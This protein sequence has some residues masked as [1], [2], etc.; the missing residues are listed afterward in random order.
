MIKFVKIL[1]FNN[2][3]KEEL[4]DK[5]VKERNINLYLNDKLI[6]RIV[7]S[8]PYEEELVFGYLFLKGYINKKNDLKRIVFK[9]EDKGHC[10]DCHTEVEN[11]SDNFLLLEKQFS[12][13]SSKLFVLMKE[14]LSKSIVFRQTGGTH[15][16]GLSDG[17]NLIS[18]FED[19]SRQSTI[20]KLAG[21]AILTD[22][23]P[24]A[25]VLFTSG[26]ISETAVQYAKRLGVMAVVS[27]SAPTDFAIEVA[28]DADIMLIGF[29]R[30]SRFNIYSTNKNLK[31]I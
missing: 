9:D 23:W 4:E 27:R 26:R 30:G 28:K 5:I 2:G 11:I 25:N 13:N 15:I 8:P 17:Q 10:T 20:F 29:L 1:R 12:I 16:S 19:V 21:D 7:Y 22:K 31:I 18:F 6:E 24:D 14:L 3:L